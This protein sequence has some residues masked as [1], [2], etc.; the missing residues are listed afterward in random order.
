LKVDNGS[1]TP[2]SLIQDIRNNSGLPTTIINTNTKLY[3]TLP[4]IKVRVYPTADRIRNNV[5]KG[6]IIISKDLPPKVREDGKTYN[7][8]AFALVDDYVVLFHFI[9]ITDPVDRNFYDVVSADMDQKPRFDLDFSYDKFPNITRDQVYMYLQQVLNAIVIVMANYKVPY[10]FEGNCLVYNSH[11]I[12]NG[13]YKY[14]FHIIIDKLVHQGVS[15][16]ELAL[17]GEVPEARA[18]Y[19]LVLDQLPNE[20]KDLGFLDSAVYSSFQNFRLPWSQKKG[21]GR[22]KILDPITQYV[23][24]YEHDPNDSH[25]I[26]ESRK[27]LGLLQASLLGFSSGCSF[28]IL[29]K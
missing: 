20:S 7:P 17:Y 9:N 1:R 13:H 15:A 6:N 19:R 8:K 26:N 27:R 3:T 2:T 4:Q 21:S 18:F 22:P 23:P 29:F 12:S 28:A 5:S 14:S 10:T 25:E 11:G 16:K 24:H